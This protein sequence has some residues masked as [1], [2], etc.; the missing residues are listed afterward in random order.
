MIQS[1][2]LGLSVNPLHYRIIWAYSRFWLAL[3]QKRPRD[4]QKGQIGPRIGLVVLSCRPSLTHSWRIKSSIRYMAC[5]SKNPSP[6][7]FHVK[8]WCLAIS[9]TAMLNPYVFIII[10][11]SCILNLALHSK[12]LTTLK[13]QK[14][15]SQ[16]TLDSKEFEGHMEGFYNSNSNQNTQ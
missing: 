14:A 9:C 5:S 1:V 2:T 8:L 7:G 4:Y 16:P 13:V 12:V 11:M 15:S 10:V 3:N 6:S